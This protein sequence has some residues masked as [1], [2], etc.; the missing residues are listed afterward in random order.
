MLLLAATLT[1][2]GAGGGSDGPASP[3]PGQ[4]ASRI[5]V[6]GGEAQVG[7]A[8]EELPS[9]VVVRVLDAAGAP[10]PGQAVNFVVTGGGGSV[11]AGVAVTNA[12]G[13]ARERWTLGPALGPQRLEA[14]AVDSATG[15]AL[16]FA[17]FEATAVAGRP[18]QVRVVTD[19]LGPVLGAIPDARVRVV[20]AGGNGVAG[21]PVTF[22]VT[23]G[24]GWLLE[25][26]AQ[27]TEQTRTTDDQGFAAAFWF[28]GSSGAQR[29][30]A[31]VTGLAPALFSLPEPEPG[32]RV[33]SIRCTLAGTVD[34][35]PPAECAA[36][37][38]ASGAWTVSA[39][40]NVTRFE[41]TL[42]RQAAASSVNSPSGEAYCIPA[43]GW[44]ATRDGVPFHDYRL[45][46]GLM[47]GST[48][49]G[50]IT[51][52]PEVTGVGPL[53]T[54]P[55]A[56]TPGAVY[57][58]TGTV[59]DSTGASRRLVLEVRV[60]QQVTVLG[61]AAPQSATSCAYAPGG[62][63]QLGVGTLDVG[64]EYA[65]FLRY[66]LPLHVRNDSAAVPGN[67]LI[68][69]NVR[70][71]VNPASY[72]FPYGVNPPPLDFTPVGGAPAR[73]SVAHSG[74]PVAAGGGESVV[75]VEAIPSDLGFVIQAA[76]VA[77]GN[78]SRYVVLGITIEGRTAAGVALKAAEYFQPVTVCQGCLP[79]ATCVAPQVET[80]LGCGVPGQDVAPVCA[81]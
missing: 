5:E 37:Q 26:E 36:E 35:F 50:T 71:A 52:V 42:D 3:V 14:R 41:L 70:V 38:D 18:S 29:M 10:V 27:V 34:G 55:S 64:P 4:V 56:V 58:L 76:A 39:A 45:C 1:A 73:A 81:G 75:V 31:R 8:G 15:A 68:I 2:C 28:L 69:E 66:T 49:P 67:D 32:P 7:A 30:E 9:P 74:P 25:P 22:V 79:R 6:V 59:S 44:T 77:A 20:D 60:D 47:S 12:A 51:F 17:T 40:A 46:Y 62:A 63:F 72:P 78:G 21:V 16:V 11:F 65:G 13:E 24:G 54:W 33:A 48:S 80:F 53:S 61:R 57:R 43:S 23:A 19:P